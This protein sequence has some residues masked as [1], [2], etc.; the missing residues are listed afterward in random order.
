MNPARC[1]KGLRQ[2]ALKRRGREYLRII[3]GLGYDLPQ[4][5]ERAAK[6]W[7]LGQAQLGHSGVLSWSPRAASI[8][9]SRVQGDSK[10][11]LLRLV[12]NVSF[13]TRGRAQ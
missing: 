5:V 6:P 1:A 11:A 9:A 12:R 10:L 2:P 4:H 7:A 8:R 3:C 13:R